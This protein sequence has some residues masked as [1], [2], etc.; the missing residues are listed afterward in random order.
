MRFRKQS[1]ALVVFA[2]FGC[3]SLV[4]SFVKEPK[5][6]FASAQVRDANADGAT[7]VIGLNIEN[8]N[9]IAL[10]VDK[11]TYA[12]ELG[13]RKV[14]TAT[15]D[16]IASVAAHTTSKIEIPVPFRYNQ[17]FASILDLI[18][19]GTAGY[20]VVGSAQIGIFNLPFD[21]SGDVKLRE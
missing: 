9:G 3:A 16:K 13:G 21:H 1:L 8:P 19:K 2:L 15:V 12:L 20:K 6:S 4:Q 18:S 5:V 17:V 11:L 7:L 10:T 14:A